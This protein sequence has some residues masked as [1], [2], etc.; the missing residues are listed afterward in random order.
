MLLNFNFS[1]FRSFRDKQSF[2]MM[3][4]DRFMSSEA[5]DCSTVTAIYGAN[6]S[7]KSNFLEALRE[8]QT[9][10][11]TSYARGD[12]SSNIFRQSFALE[13]NAGQ[14]PS[15]FFVEFIAN[16]QL[17]Y[18]Y[19]FC[20]D[21]SRIIDEELVYFRNIDGRLSTHSSLLFHRGEDG[22][23]KFGSMFKGP[24]TQVRQTIALRP[25]ALLLSAS[26]AA[27][28]KSI[29]SAYSFFRNDISYHDSRAFDQEQPILIEEFKNKTEYARKINALIKYADFGITSVKSEPVD[30]PSE[31][32]NQ[33]KEEMRQLGADEMKLEKAFPARSENQLKFVHATKAGGIEFG[34]DNE[35]VG[36]IAALSFFSLALRQLARPT[37][38]LVDEIDTSLHPTLVK[39][40]VSLYA[41]PE[42][43]PHG[44]QLIFTTHDVSLI[45]QS[46]VAHRVLQPDQVWLIEK[47]NDGA[48]EL[49]SMTDIKGLRKDENIGRNYLNGV[50][51]AV[52]VLS[53]HE[54][55]ARMM[56]EGDA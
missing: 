51:G 49:F 31:A 22:S 30:F 6:A 15:T 4:D 13:D 54:A 27:G 10:V 35:S 40:L 41:D 23:V 32:W 20:Y 44:S 39:E 8:M 28:I 1:N 37:V 56:S 33:F 47:G 43:N 11:V 25:T 55:F 24:K 12:S 48:S 46:G 29:Q 17:K 7:G 18:Q 9:M 5:S 45:N 50:Y 19:S 42:T 2:T 21:D 16:D 53:F 14:R 36:T 52:P 3:R 34:T 26:A 38:T